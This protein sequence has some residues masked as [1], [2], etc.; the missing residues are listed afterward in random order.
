MDS[1]LKYS[2]PFRLYGHRSKTLEKANFKKHG[3]SLVPLT[4]VYKQSFLSYK[5]SLFTDKNV[6]LVMSILLL[7][8]MDKWNSV[9]LALLMHMFNAFKLLVSQATV[10]KGNR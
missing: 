10:R 9:S 4:I 2:H 3:L 6:K 1:F 8:A 5:L 7:S